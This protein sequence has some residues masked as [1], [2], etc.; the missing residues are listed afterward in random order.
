M[1]NEQLDKLQ[2]MLN[3]LGDNNYWE[4]FYNDEILVDEFN[5]KLQLV[6][7]SRTWL[8]KEIKKREML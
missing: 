2:D 6:K 3:K 7:N 8:G 1:S 5:N 4:P